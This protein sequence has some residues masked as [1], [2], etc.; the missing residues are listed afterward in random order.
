MSFRIKSLPS[1]LS[2]SG[3]FPVVAQFI[4]NRRSS[5]K[6]LFTIEPKFWD[7]INCRVKKA[8]NDHVRLNTI[9]ADANAQYASK[10]L[11]FTGNHANEF[12]KEIDPEENIYT[13]DQAF[14]NKISRHIRL[15]KHSAATKYKNLRSK[16]LQYGFDLKINISAINSAWMSEFITRLQEDPKLG[17]SST[18]AKNIGFLK[19]VIRAIP[20]ANYPVD[21]NIFRFNVASRSA[22]RPKLSLGLTRQL[23]DLPLKPFSSIAISR[24]VF[25]LQFYLWGKRIRDILTLQPRFIIGDQIVKPSSKTDKTSSIDISPEAWNIINRYKGH[26]KYY[27]IP[28]LKLDPA[29]SDTA[30]YNKHIESYT[31]VVNKNLKTLAYMLDININLTSHVARHSFAHLAYIS[32]ASIREIQAMLEHSSLEKTEIYLRELANSERLNAIAKKLY[33]GL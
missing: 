22:I 18:V 16:L 13:L 32:G 21:K 31:A 5:R 8:H 25:L 9:I 17:S 3:L 7:P 12:F 27:I 1:E 15:K 29:L 23:I 2:S 11:H 20:D 33:D 28:L 4:F 6:V 24:D 10:A 19:A 30:E 26:S 14:E